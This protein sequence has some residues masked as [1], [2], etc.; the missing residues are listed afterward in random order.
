MHLFELYASKCALVLL[1]PSHQAS[2]KLM[3]L[4]WGNKHMRFMENLSKQTALI[5]LFKSQFG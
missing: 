1:V 2:L 4:Q 5:E 3:Y